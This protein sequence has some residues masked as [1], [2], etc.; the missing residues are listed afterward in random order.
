MVSSKRHWLPPFS[1]DLHKPSDEDCVGRWERDSTS[2][3]GSASKMH[4]CSMCPHVTARIWRNYESHVRDIEVHECVCNEAI[5]LHYIQL[6]T[7]TTFPA[8]ALLL[9]VSTSSVMQHLKRRVRQTRQKLMKD[10]I[11]VFTCPRYPAVGSL[12]V[13]WFQS[14]SSF[15]RLLV[16]SEHKARMH[17][18]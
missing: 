5:T 8:L 16:L 3:T 9:V 7:H 18:I 2:F 11:S 12:T 13:D 10:E 14:Y 15:E 6:L 4:A 1:A 17:L